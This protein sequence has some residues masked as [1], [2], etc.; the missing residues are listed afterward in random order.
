MITPKILNIYIRCKIYLTEF[1]SSKETN[2]FEKAI[3]FI[4]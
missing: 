4:L 3:N 2:Y 1:E